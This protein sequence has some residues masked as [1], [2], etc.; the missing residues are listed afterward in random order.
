MVFNSLTYLL[1]LCI[2]VFLFW[3]ISY[4]YRFFLIFLSSL[5]FYGFWKIEFIPLLLFSTFLDWWIGL[6]MVNFTGKKKK[7][8]L[9]FSLSVNL[10]ILFF[11]KYLIFFTENTLSLFNLFDIKL[12][13]IVFKII[14]P[15]GISF[16]TFQTISY[17]IDVYKNF[18]KPEKSF[19]IYACYVTFFPQL[20]AGPILRAKEVM[21]QFKRFNYFEWNYIIQGLR[22]ILYGLFLKVV[23]ADNIAPL[24][25]SGFGLPISEISA[26]D[27][28]TLTFLFGFQ[29]YFDF[30]GYSHIALGSAKMIGITFP[31]NFNF[32]YM[33]NSPKDF[34][35][36]WHI[37]LSSWVRD[38]IYFPLLKIKF[39]N[40]SVGGLERATLNK[41]DQITLFITWGLMGFWH[42][43][44]WTFLIWGLYHAFFI[45]IYRLS[46]PLTD[47]LK[48]KNILGWLFTLPII[49][50]SWIPFRSNSIETSF[51][52][53]IKVINPINYNYLGLQENTYII[54]VLIILGFLITYYV[55]EKITKNRLSKNI[56]F[57]IGDIFFISFLFYFTFIFLRPINQFIYFQF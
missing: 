38:Y 51:Q 5:I 52:M 48:N 41:N 16:Y 47:K 4:Y 53:W 8:L 20:I 49:M 44:N 46:R 9:I 19:I 31:E 24:V 33:A 6:N 29:I 25:D 27:V 7:Y 32:P 37:S 12:D 34:W 10:G 14:L 56:I 42:G 1:L 18:I 28:W 11:F 22:R 30:C 39:Q 45:L 26:L 50:L 13:P 21:P 35:R 3:N 36:R 43:A 55:K 17:T 2:V 57:F 54:T 23:I 40:S 15:L